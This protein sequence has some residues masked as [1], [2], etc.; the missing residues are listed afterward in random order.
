MSPFTRVP[1]WVLNVYHHF[2]WR[3]GLAEHIGGI[4][5]FPPVTLA[6]EDIFGHKAVCLFESGFEITFQSI[7]CIRKLLGFVVRLLSQK[8]ILV[9]LALCVCVV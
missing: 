8:Y 9:N 5:L 3:Q 2:Q 7:I 4:L 6:V 1:V